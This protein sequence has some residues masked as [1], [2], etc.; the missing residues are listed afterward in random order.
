MSLLIAVLRL[1]HILSGIVWVGGSF[2][3]VAF[4]LPTARR[5]GPDSGRFMQSLAAES[6]LP[7][8]MTVAASLAVVAGLALIWLVS[9]RFDPAWM[10]SPMGITLSVGMVFGLLAYAHGFAVQNVAARRMGALTRASAAGGAPPTAEQAAQLLALREKLARGA[11]TGTWLM[12]I[13][14]AAMAIARY[15]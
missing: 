3:L 1:V 8:A 14:V 5:T 15:I 13:T 7:Q 10:G 6:G 4:V 9:G 12:A 2:F 11:R